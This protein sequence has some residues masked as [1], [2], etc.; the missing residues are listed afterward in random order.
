MLRRAAGPWFGLT[1]KEQQAIAVI[2]ALALLG[3]A[4]KFWHMSQQRG[5]DPSPAQGLEAPAAC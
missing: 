3:L 2:S 5:D 4:V 1:S